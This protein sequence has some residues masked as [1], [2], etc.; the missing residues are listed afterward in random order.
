MTDLSRLFFALLVLLLIV[1]QTPN[2]NILLRTF[3]ETQIFANYGEA[4]RVLT[5]LTW[6]CIF[7]FLFIT[8]FSALK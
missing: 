2:E 3:Y 5:I 1:P 7:I 4:K 6:S 8:F